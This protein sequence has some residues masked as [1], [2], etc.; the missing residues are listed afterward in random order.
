[1]CHPFRT[2]L[3]G[4]RIYRARI[5]ADTPSGRLYK[6]AGRVE[7][8]DEYL[9]LQTFRKG[10][11]LFI[12]GAEMAKRL[13]SDSARDAMLETIETFAP[14]PPSKEEVERFKLA[15]IKNIEL[16]FND[17]NTV[18][19]LMTDWVAQGDWRIVF[20]Y[21]DS[22]RKVTPEDVQRVAKST[23]LNSQ[24]ARLGYSFRPKSPTV[25]TSAGQ[26]HRNSR[27]G[28]RSQRRRGLADR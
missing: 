28:K 3:S 8:G 15:A 22:M 16:S 2:R 10:T 23:F 18:A 19:L 12:F 20:L 6:I 14:S 26:R 7:K 5:L 27:N 9:Q 1:M 24:I 11:E 13:L 4:N 21:R 17:P 25:Q